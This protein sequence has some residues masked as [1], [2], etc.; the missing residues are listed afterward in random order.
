MNI[1]SF[2]FSILFI[3]SFTFYACLENDMMIRRI[4]KT[5]IGQTNVSRKICAAYETEAYKK[6]RTSVK[7]SAS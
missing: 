6:E 1:L 2:V 4:N 3:L 5:F 7:I